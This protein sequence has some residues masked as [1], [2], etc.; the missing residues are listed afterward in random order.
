MN[1]V[2]R[3]RKI[4]ANSCRGVGNNQNIADKQRN[5]RDNGNRRH[6]IKGVALLNKSTRHRET[7]FEF[8]IKREMPRR[9]RATPGQTVERMKV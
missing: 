7:P 9:L 3:P 1:L 2:N 6:K 4:L 8:G 5:T